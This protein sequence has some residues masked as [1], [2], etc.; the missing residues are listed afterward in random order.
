MAVLA[1]DAAVAGFLAVP[2]TAF[3]GLRFAWGNPMAAVLRWCMAPV[4]AVRGGDTKVHGQRMHAAGIT[5]RHLHSETASV[6]V[7]TR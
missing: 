4:T 3:L 2:K 5:G 6:T 1:M 7:S